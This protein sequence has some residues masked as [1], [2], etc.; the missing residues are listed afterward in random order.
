MK[1]GDRVRVL[2]V[3]ESPGWSN[4]YADRTGIII[5]MIPHDYGDYPVVRLDGDG[6]TT[7]FDWCDVEV[8]NV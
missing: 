1:V 3:P 5:E 4:D 2:R 6:T 8:I 7:S